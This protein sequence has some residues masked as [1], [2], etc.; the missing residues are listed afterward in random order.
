MM[1]TGKKDGKDPHGRS[2]HPSLC[3]GTSLTPAWSRPNPRQEEERQIQGLEHP[4]A[5]GSYGFHHVWRAA[6][7]RL[8][9]QLQLLLP[10]QC[11]LSLSLALPKTTRT[12]R[13]A[14]PPWAGCLVLCA[15]CSTE[16]QRQTE[17]KWREHSQDAETR[18]K[19][20]HP[21]EFSFPILRSVMHSHNS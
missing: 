10:W 12:Q 2:C 6:Q 21:A 7:G 3:L 16:L 13:T 15:Q 18:G 14:R 4:I 11:Q 8:G 17:L 1:L 5:A 9:S 20:S 19:N